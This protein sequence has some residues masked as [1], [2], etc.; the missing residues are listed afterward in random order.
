MDELGR[1]LQLAVLRATSTTTE[2]TR[3]LPRFI[4]ADDPAFAIKSTQ[5]AAVEAA[6]GQA[7]VVGRIKLSDEYL[8]AAHKRAKEAS[9]RAQDATSN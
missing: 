6:E 5:G 8:K 3:A 4:P 9:Q 2:K 7:K 1:K